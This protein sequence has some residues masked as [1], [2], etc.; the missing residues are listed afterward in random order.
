MS[1]A[2]IANVVASQPAGF[3]V[4]SVI[5]VMLLG[6]WQRIAHSMKLSTKRYRASRQTC[7]VS[8]DGVGISPRWGSVA[9]MYRPEIT[10]LLQDTNLSMHEDK[11]GGS[12]EAAPVK[13]KNIMM[14][15]AN[16][17]STVVSAVIAAVAAI[18][19]AVVP[20][21][22]KNR[23][24][25]QE[26][27]KKE[28]AYLESLQ[29]IVNLTTRLKG[30]ERFGADRIILFRGHNSGGYPTPGMPYYVSASQ[31]VCSDPQ[32]DGH[33]ENYRNL[34]VDTAYISMILSAATNELRHVHNVTKNMPHSQLRRYYEMEGVVE[35]AVFVLGIYGKT[36]YFISAA[37]HSGKFSQ[38]DLTAMQLE[39][40]AIWQ[41]MQPEK[42]EK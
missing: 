11:S 19:A 38:N 12:G 14:A 29:R 41:D 10:K 42:S 17:N 2:T 5:G 26:D 20:L 37:R 33:I 4:L 36:L 22:Y 1:L 25:P 24:K 34:M 28:S 6:E 21:W 27:A 8:P 9:R 40:N 30:F 31:W 32:S 16:D 3:G 35:S 7:P 18:G 23:Q 13:S 39:A 15:E